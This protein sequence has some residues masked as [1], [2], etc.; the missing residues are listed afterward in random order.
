M[1]W[2]RSGCPGLAGFWG[3]V[4]AIRAALYPAPGLPRT[5]Y[6]V[7]AVL[8]ALGVVLT[9]AYFL[10]LVR[11]LLQGTPVAATELA[12]TTPSGLDQLDQRLSV[13]LTTEQVE[14][15]FDRRPDVDGSEW[16]VW[17]PLLLLIVVLG[18]APGL[19]LTPVGEAAQ[20]FLGWLR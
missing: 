14:P 16:L 9:A 11:R 7:L 17:S 15:G 8:A 20:A 4:L 3:E 18:V 1:R 10:A 5:T 6:V 2:P 13:E 19:L 12:G